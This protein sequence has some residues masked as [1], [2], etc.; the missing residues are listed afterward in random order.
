MTRLATSHASQDAALK[1]FI[2][3]GQPVEAACDY[4]YDALYRLTAAS[5]RE[6]SG[7][8][9]FDFNPPNGDYRDYPF[10]GQRVHANDLQGLRGYVESIATMRWA[11]SCRWCTMP[12]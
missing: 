3:D 7:Q 11:T 2:Q 1:T 12:A 4:I 6:H 5:G 8:T 10:A 9:G